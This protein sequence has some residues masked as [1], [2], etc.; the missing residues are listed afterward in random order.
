[1][2]RR[3]WQR[4]RSRDKKDLGES[5]GYMRGGFKQLYTALEKDLVSRGVDL[6]LNTPVA[7]IVTSPDQVVV[8]DVTGVAMVKV[9]A[10]GT[11]DA[12]GRQLQAISTGA[13]GISV[14]DTVVTGTTDP[15][16][17]ALLVTRELQPELRMPAA[18][19][20]VLR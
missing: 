10:T 13:A 11:H 16:V 18:C 17:A 4:A 15:L 19:E 12:G 9:T 2:Q 5:L 3:C 7:R 6:R 1:M 20:R 8:Y 14:G